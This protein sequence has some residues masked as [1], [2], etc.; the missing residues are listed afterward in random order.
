M[1]ATVQ[2]DFTGVLSELPWRILRSLDYK[3]LPSSSYQAESTNPISRNCTTYLIPS[4]QCRVSL[5]VYVPI[6]NDAFSTAYMISRPG[7]TGNLSLRR[8]DVYLVRTSAVLSPDL[9]AVSTWV[10]SVRLQL[11]QLRV[12]PCIQADR[13]W[14]SPSIRYERD[15]K[16]EKSVFLCRISNPRCP[17]QPL[18]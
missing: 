2:G 12:L 3:Q 14:A 8:Y 18:T 15:G 13:P 17:A 5:K 11:L 6:F 16:V 4:F 7:D 9:G 1:K 10:I